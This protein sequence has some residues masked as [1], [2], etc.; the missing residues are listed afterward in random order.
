MVLYDLW[1]LFLGFFLLFIPAYINIFLKF[2]QKRLV[3]IDFD[4]KFDL[5][6]KKQINFE[7]RFKG[8][9][10]LNFLKKVDKIDNVKLYVSI[11]E[12]HKEINKISSK[13]MS[14]ANNFKIF[15]KDYSFNGFKKCYEKNDN[16]KINF[17]FKCVK[18]SDLKKPKIFCQTKIIS[19]TFYFGVMIERKGIDIRKYKK[20]E[21]PID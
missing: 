20:Y 19:R 6:E 16:I 17:D 1:L 2:Y 3:K 4:M 8:V 9:V 10:R 7:E 13:R 11:Y 18:K 21:L 14:Y 5:N 12:F 15:E